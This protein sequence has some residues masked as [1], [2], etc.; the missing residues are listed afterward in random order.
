MA[1]QGP[2]AAV[3][4]LNGRLTTRRGE[5]GRDR[6]C[7]PGDTAKSTLRV[8]DDVLLAVLSP[9][10]FGSHL[11][12][13]DERTAHSGPSGRKYAPVRITAAAALRL[14]DR[15][16]GRSPIRLSRGTSLISYGGRHRLDLGP[17]RNQTASWKLSGFLIGLLVTDLSAFSLVCAGDSRQLSESRQLP[18]SF[19][20]PNRIF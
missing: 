7:R 20:D 2:T 6:P 10:C 1:F 8:A 18:D 4:L 14:A 19:P 5:H 3:T 17:T 16:S 11:S 13:F 15:T 9:R 12:S